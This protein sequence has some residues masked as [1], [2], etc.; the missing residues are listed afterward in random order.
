MRFL[1]TA[2]VSDDFKVMGVLIQ[3][4][5]ADIEIAHLPRLSLVLGRKKIY[6]YV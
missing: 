4:V 5:G 6:I 3:I 2:I 1:R